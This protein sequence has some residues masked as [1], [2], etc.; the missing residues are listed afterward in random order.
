MD[1][2]HLF[3]LSMGLGKWNVRFASQEK[4]RGMPAGNGKR[5]MLSDVMVLNLLVPPLRTWHMT[6]YEGFL[7]W[8][9]G[10]VGHF[11]MRLA[12]SKP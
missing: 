5:E 2:H 6:A 12:P 3:L 7:S 8:Y 4:S 11:N 9:R 1:G 10:Q